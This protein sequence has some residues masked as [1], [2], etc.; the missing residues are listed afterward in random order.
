MMRIVRSRWTGLISVALVM[1]GLA[2]VA[3][4]VSAGA[5][6]R[7][8]RTVEVTSTYRRVI[9]P[10]DPTNPPTQPPAILP[11][12]TC[13][14][15]VNRLKETVFGYEHQGSLA[16]RAD[17]GTQS[18]PLRGYNYF[19]D[20]SRT[21]ADLGQLDQFLP[22]SHPSRFAVQTSRKP[23]W[24]LEVPSVG[25]EGPRPSSDLERWRISIKPRRAACGSSVPEHFA[26]MR[27][28]GF[29]FPAPVDIVRDPTGRITQYSL[30]SSLSEFRQTLCSPGGVPVD[31]RVV[32]GYTEDNLVPLPS[33][34]VIRVDDLDH[35]SFTR[36]EV[37]TR[38]VADASAGFQLR[39]IVDVYARCQFENDLVEAPDPRWDGND[40]AS[41][42]GVGPTQ[43]NQEIRVQLFDPG[44]GVRFR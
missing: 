28:S 42:F 15:R 44:G 20:G 41:W 5:A 10:A 16:Y 11:T 25:A 27:N 43:G 6:S 36:T 34:Q 29:S 37:A 22:G 7:R 24:I 19:L 14:R 13:V 40:D 35:R 12:V 4:P 32:F 1:S 9:E 30:D 26:S 8:N 39:V 33:G 21:I 31:P 38:Q 18:T 17:P 3:P 23:T 2:T